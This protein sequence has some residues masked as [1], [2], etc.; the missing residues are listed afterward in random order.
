MPSTTAQGGVPRRDGIMSLDIRL[1]TTLLHRQ[2]KIFANKSA[3][4]QEDIHIRIFS[5]QNEGV[6]H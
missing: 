1:Q 4:T 6:L 3:S 2:V 5:K